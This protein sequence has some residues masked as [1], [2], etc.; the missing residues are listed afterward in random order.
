VLAF[1]ILNFTFFGVTAC[2]ETNKIVLQKGTHAS[3]EAIVILTTI[4]FFCT[5]LF[6]AL[7]LMNPGYVPK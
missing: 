4:A 1:D 6:Y 5:A 7:T 2:F 3:L